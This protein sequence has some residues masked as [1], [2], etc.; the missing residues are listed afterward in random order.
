MV[1]AFTHAFSAVAIGSAFPPEA[2]PR[3]WW[4]VG[5]LLAAAP[6]LDA[7]GH[8]SGVP[9]EHLCGH[10]GLTHSPFVALVAAGAIA[11]VARRRAA[12]G[13]EPARI[14]ALFAYLAL[15]MGSHGVLDALTNG[16]LGIAFLA[17]FSDAR[18]FLPWNP[19]EVAPISVRGFFTA[20]GLEV[21][22]SEVR[23]VWLPGAVL[24]AMTWAG[25]RLRRRRRGPAP[26]A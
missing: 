26:R 22:L 7:I 9:Y 19:I 1:S 25:R 10:R 11:L 6:D 18:W 23:W 8:W 4:I 12:A 17:P 21:F 15:C 24:M 14:W 20:R 2:L 13:A 5:A 3:R 16:G